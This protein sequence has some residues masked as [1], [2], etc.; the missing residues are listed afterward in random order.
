MRQD[1]VACPDVLLQTSGWLAMFDS[2]L[3]PRGGLKQS[4]C[5][6][7]ANWLKKGGWPINAEGDRKSEKM[8][9]SPIWGSIGE[10]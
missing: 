6:I 10:R 5:R 8:S 9:I 7:E 2:V 1:F 3:G 4:C